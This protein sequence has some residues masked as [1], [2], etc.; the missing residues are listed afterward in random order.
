VSLRDATG[1]ID[2]DER[3]GSIIVL[4]ATTTTK[5]VPVPVGLALAVVVALAAVD[6]GFWDG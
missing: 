2:L 1:R 4:R 5:L 3:A 6:N